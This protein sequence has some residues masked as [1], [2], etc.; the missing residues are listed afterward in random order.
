MRTLRA[1]DQLR[2]YRKVRAGIRRQRRRVFEDF[3]KEMDEIE[4]ER[5][6]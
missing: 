2:E 4:K 6:R 3:M 1:D 5:E